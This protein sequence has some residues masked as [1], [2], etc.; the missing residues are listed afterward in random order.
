MK[1]AF[2]LDRDGTINVD[3]GYVMRPEDVVLIPGAGNAIHA[4]NASG[5]LVIVISNQSGVA[6]G[7]GTIEDV[8]RVNARIQELLRPFHAHIDA[9]YICPHHKDGIIKKYA[10]ECT[11]RKPGM[12]LFQRAI[13]DFGLCAADCAAAGDKERDIMNA[14]DIGI[15]KTVLFT[16]GYAEILAI[17]AGGQSNA[18]AG[19]V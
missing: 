16:G 18:G 19:Q 14:G 2:F 4:M 10:V 5:W 7:Y 17:V 15:K 12:G 1:R 9:F 11:C 6:R 3:T 8:D 13:A